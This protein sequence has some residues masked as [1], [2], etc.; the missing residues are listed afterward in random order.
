M[1][2]KIPHIISISFCI[3]A[4]KQD[5]TL[6]P[7]SF[8]SLGLCLTGF[9]EHLCVS[10]SLYLFICLCYW[11]YIKIQKYF[12]F[13]FTNYPGEERIKNAKNSSPSARMN[14]IWTKVKIDPQIIQNHLIKS[15]QVLIDYYSRDSKVHVF[16]S[17]PSLTSKRIEPK[18]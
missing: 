2:R 11:P 4:S 12:T 15:P 6:V 13:S 17:M 7:L 5:H 14:F 18:Q 3:I 1:T 16:I 10:Y 9:T 8:S